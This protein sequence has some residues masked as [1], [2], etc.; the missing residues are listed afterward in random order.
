[1]SEGDNAFG[2]AACKV[3]GGALMVRVVSG[4]A[5][6]A[7]PIVRAVAGLVSRVLAVTLEAVDVG[8]V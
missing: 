8:W 4:P 3:G 6:P 7:T 5:V 1:M 2:C